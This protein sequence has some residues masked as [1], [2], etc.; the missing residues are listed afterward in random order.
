[1]LCCGGGSVA[2]DPRTD[3]QI[4][5]L[6][7]RSST[8]SGLP[9]S[10]ASVTTDLALGGLVSESDCRGVIAMY[11]VRFGLSP[12]DQIIGV[13]AASYWVSGPRPASSSMVRSIETWL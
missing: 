6:S 11:G 1:M 2:C 10:S 3:V 7:K 13:A 5:L 8:W 9:C 4:S 12:N